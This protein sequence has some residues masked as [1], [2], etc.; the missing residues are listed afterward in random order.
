MNRQ[1]FGGAPL[2]PLLVPPVVEVR[3]LFQRERQEVLHLRQPLAGRR[4][5]AQRVDAFLGR[6]APHDQEP[7]ALEER[8]VPKVVVEPVVVTALPRLADLRHEPHLL[9]VPHGTGNSRGAHRQ[10]RRQIGGRE[11]TF[12]GRHQGR[13]DAGG[14]ALHPDLR[15]HEAQAPTYRRTASSSRCVVIR[16]SSRTPQAM[17]TRSRH[18]LNFTTS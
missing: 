10:L 18:F 1:A 7:V 6:V 11:L 2:R 8:G 16:P 9:Q 3:D 17:I 14:H 12:V 15:Q 4:V 5:R 13:E